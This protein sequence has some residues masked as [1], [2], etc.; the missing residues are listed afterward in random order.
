MRVVPTVLVALALLPA[1]PSAARPVPEDLETST[2]PLTCR[3]SAGGAVVDRGSLRL[4]ADYVV[5]GDDDPG[6]LVPKGYT[7]DGARGTWSW[8]GSSAGFEDGPLAGATGAYLSRRGTL[9]GEPSGRLYS[10]LVTTPAGEQWSCGQR[11]RLVRRAI[12]PRLGAYVARVAGIPVRV[13]AWFTDVVSAAGAR[14]RVMTLSRGY[15]RLAIGEAIFSAKRKPASDLGH[16]T[17]VDLGNGVVGW[18]GSY[19]CAFNGDD[20]DWGPKYCGRDAIVWHQA[21]VNYCLESVSTGDA[22]LVASARQAV[23]DAPLA[24]GR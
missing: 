17:R 22:D 20:P 5:N 11:G 10:L 12:G 8:D 16:R 14:P 15:Y 24:G 13:P 19:G 3:A 7:L 6:H 23:A 1:V 18:V 2:Y 9:A 4:V 21:G